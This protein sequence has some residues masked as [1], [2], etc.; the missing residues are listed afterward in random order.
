MQ[1]FSKDWQ[2]LGDK[3]TLGT[4]V[5]VITG[6]DQDTIEG[7]DIRRV[8]IARRM[9]WA[10][11]RTTTRKEDIAYCLLGIFGVNMP[12]LYG[13]GERAFSRLQE[14]I[15]KVSDDQ[16]L[17]AWEDQCEDGDELLIDTGDA[18]LR[19]P[20]ARFPAEFANSGDIV[21]YRQMQTSRPSATTNYGLQVDVPLYRLR[22]SS[23]KAPLYLAELTCHYEGDFSGSLGIYVRPLRSDQFARDHG[24]RAPVVVDPKLHYPPV[25]STIYLRKDV[26][27]PSTEEFDRHHGILVHLHPPEHSFKVSYVFPAE[28]WMRIKGKST[29]VLNPGRY[30]AVVFRNPDDTLITVLMSHEQTNELY[31]SYGHDTWEVSKCR[32]KVF[33]YDSPMGTFTHE[34]LSS[35]EGHLKYEGARTARFESDLEGGTDKTFADMRNGRRVVAKMKETIM[36]ERM[37]FV[38]VNIYEVG[39]GLCQLSGISSVKDPPA[40]LQE[41][42]LPLQDSLPPP[43]GGSST[44]YQ[45]PPPTQPLQAFAHAPLQPGHMQGYSVNMP[46][47]QQGFLLLL[48]QIQMQYTQTPYE[49]YPPVS[50]RPGENTVSSLTGSITRADPSRAYTRLAKWIQLMSVP[51]SLDQRIRLCKPTMYSFGCSFCF[52]PLLSWPA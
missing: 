4:V 20:F 34:G 28:Q 40:W 13:E 24:K 2:Y 7:S 15:M 48:S 50:F 23:G 10:S 9:F 19:G 1:F 18:L 22:N 31:E 47:G 42:A 36:G 16:S 51:I 41:N 39:D 14:E 44:L 43:Q 26:F 38:H 25:Q 30:A 49:Y 52:F 12:L 46:N 29:I 3:A 32:C 27:L 5:S 37:I 11:Q 35:M 6:I 45:P 21:P 8:S 17:F 33:I